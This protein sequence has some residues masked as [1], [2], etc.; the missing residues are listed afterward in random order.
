M[1]RRHLLAVGAG[2]L[3]APSIAR[4]QDKYPERTVR[5]VVPFAPAGPT[6][7]IGRMIA[8]KMT[9]ALGQ[10][11]IVENKAGGAGV[12]GAN[13]IKTARPDGYRPAV[14]DVVDPRH[15]AD[16]D[17]QGAVRS[18]QG[19]HADLVGLRQSP[20]AGRP[21][22]DA[23]YGE[24]PG[25]ADEGE[26]GQIFLRTSGTAASFI[27]PPSTSNARS[28]ARCRP[29]ALSRFGAGD[30]GP[31]GREGG[32]GCSRPSARRCSIARPAN[33]APPLGPQTRTQDS[34]PYPELIARLASRVPRGGSRW[35]DG[36]FGRVND[37]GLRSQSPHSSSVSGLCQPKRLFLQCLPCVRV[38]RR[39]VTGQWVAGLAPQSWAAPGAGRSRGAHYWSLQLRIGR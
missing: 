24:R 12:I 29:C 23:G 26:S 10:T 18:H 30:P 32:A 7:I 4:A 37:M 9:A 34:H 5:L 17:D 39:P 31:A 14:R 25:R 33:C 2:A 3:A 15:P 6:D 38:R 1:R 19:L 22:V 21:S 35:Q 28:A 16:G 13:E 11:M 20:G 27:S 36:L 8:E